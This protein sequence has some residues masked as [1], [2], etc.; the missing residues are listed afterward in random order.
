MASKYADEFS[1]EHAANN[2]ADW[3]N[4]DEKTRRGLWDIQLYFRIINLEYKQ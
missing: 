3:P 2:V 1:K 4:G